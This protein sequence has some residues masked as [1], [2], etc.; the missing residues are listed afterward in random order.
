MRAASRSDL[1]YI[2]WEKKLAG[3]KNIDLFLSVN[4][5]NAISL[6]KCYVLFRGHRNSPFKN[7]LAVF[8]NSSAVI[9]SVNLGDWGLSLYLTD[10]FAIFEGHPTKRFSKFSLICFVIGLKL[11]RTRVFVTK[12]LIDFFQRKWKRTLC[13]WVGWRLFFEVL[14][15]VSS[16]LVQS[17]LFC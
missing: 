12:L 16:S 6:N 14:L 2:S 1:L 3:N 17:K 15:S 5:I 10:Q 4:K 11:G 9:Q 13:F 8:V 7:Y